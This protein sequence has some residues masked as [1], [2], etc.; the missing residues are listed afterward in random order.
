MVAAAQVQSLNF[1][2]PTDAA[3]HPRNVPRKEVP[4][5]HAA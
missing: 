5:L 2:L 4:L 1:S 3:G